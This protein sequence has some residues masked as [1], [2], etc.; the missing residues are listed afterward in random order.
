MSLKKNKISYKALLLIN[1]CLVFG[2]AFLIGNSV[3]KAQ[4]STVIRY[5]DAPEATPPAPQVTSQTTA[6]TR[7]TNQTSKTVAANTRTT[8]SIPATA[9]FPEFKDFLN[10]TVVPQIPKPGEDV[11]ISLEIYSFDIN[12]ANIT[13]KMDGKEVAKGTGLKSY[14]FKNKPAG[15]TTTIVAT[16]EPYDRPKVEKTFTFTPGEVDIL[17]QSAVYT[18]PFYKGKGLYTPEAKLLFVAMPRTSSGVVSPRETIFKWRVNYNNDAANS[19]FGRNTYSLDGPIILRPINVSVEVQEPDEGKS[20]A[21]TD[22]ELE[23]KYPSV[24]LYEN[25]PLYGVLFNKAL[26]NTLT[27]NKSELSISAYPFSHSVQSKNSDL[28]YIWSVDTSN[29]SIPKNQ[30]TITLRRNQ[31]DSGESL[32]SLDLVNPF[33]ILQSSS[34][35]LVIRFDL[36]GFSGFGQSTQTDFGQAE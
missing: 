23:N 18:P 6:N 8:G 21:S 22:M 31:G 13:W 29:I 14:T 3:A 1:S 33:K 16:V 19:G 10:S 28:Q 12:S 30:N 34:A 9:A 24:H 2:L 20:Y 4:N 26:R 5:F 25:N 36:R 27:L 17:W 15:Q 7:A 32:V 11:K 35:N